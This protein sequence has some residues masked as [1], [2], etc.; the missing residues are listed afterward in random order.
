MIFQMSKGT[1][2]YIMYLIRFIP[3]ELISWFWYQIGNHIAMW[4]WCIRE[5]PFYF[6]RR[7]WKI[8]GKK[9]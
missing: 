2:R 7:A 4:P 3:E 1:P 9:L 5:G 8:L 6:C